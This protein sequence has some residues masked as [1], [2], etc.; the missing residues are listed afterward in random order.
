MAPGPEKTS[1][2]AAKSARLLPLDDVDDRSGVARGISMRRKVQCSARQSP[3]GRLIFIAS[4]VRNTRTVGPFVRV[5]D[6]KIARS[7][8]ASSSNTRAKTAE[9]TTTPDWYTLKVPFPVQSAFIVTLAEIV[10][11]AETPPLLLVCVPERFPSAS[12]LNRPTPATG[13]R[14]VGRMIDPVYV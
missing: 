12:K 8:F 9:R 14:P 10:S 3:L 7:S 1:K 13:T 6:S 5:S 2:S 4:T 11:C